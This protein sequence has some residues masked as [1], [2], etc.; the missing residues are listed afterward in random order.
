MKKLFVTSRVS[1]EPPLEKPA[2][3]SKGESPSRFF[4]E[5]NGRSE[6]VLRICLACM[7]LLLAF[8][9]AGTSA[10]AFPVLVSGSLYFDDRM[11]GDHDGCFS[12]T[13]TEGRFS[14][15]WQ[16]RNATAAS[17]IYEKVYYRAAG[18]SVWEE[19][20]STAPFSLG[21]LQ[22]VDHG[23][24]IPVDASCIEWEYKVELWTGS[25]RIV[26]AG[27]LTGRQ[28]E[29]TADEDGGVAPDT[30][31]PAIAI[32]A[33]TSAATYATTLAA[34][35]IAGTASDATGV[36][37]VAWVNNRGGGG[38]ASGTAAWSVASIALQLGANVITVTARDAAGNT[39]TDTLTVTYSL[40]GDTIPPAVTITVPTSAVV[41]D[42]TVAAVGIS[43]T[44]SDA[45]G[46][47]QVTWS[48]SR[49]GSGTAT[50]TVNWSVAG[51]SLQPGSNVITITAR[52][53]A[54]NSS[55]DTL[56]VNLGTG[57]PVLG[58]L[59]LYSGFTVT[60]SPGQAYRIEASPTANVG[61]WT[62][63]GTITLTSG[64]QLWIDTE[65]PLGGRASRFYRAV[66]Q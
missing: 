23:V 4:R 62:A 64:T 50:G 39:A 58:P 56:T 3:D 33:P 24:L 61:P 42:T 37:Q 52:D 60:G 1:P 15:N 19:L 29:E 5:A 10:F 20:G 35:G 2:P 27:S 59:A 28:R 6:R 9:T 63:V 12:G 34:I 65:T 48:N 18:G 57:G 25:S 40:P 32:T 51:I 21:Q 47:T 13:S 55:T 30:T 45:V 36:T 46:V 16:I 44:A 26:G 53:A 43:G 14:L 38:T 31:P 54:G 7:A 22:V 66:R 17:G 11:D 49:G 41:F 8:A